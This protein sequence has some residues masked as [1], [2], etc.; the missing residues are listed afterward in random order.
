M[1]KKVKHIEPI[2]ITGWRSISN[3]LE[4]LDSRV[5]PGVTGAEF[6]SLFVHC[7]CGLILTCQAFR[8]YG[9]FKEVIDLTGKHT[10]PTG[11]D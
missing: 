9:C 4:L 8:Q 2:C 6:E 11:N 1:H 3:L 10:D 7:E 5:R